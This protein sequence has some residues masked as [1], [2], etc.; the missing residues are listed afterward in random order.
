MKQKK[1]QI[2]FNTI[3]SRLKLFDDSKNDSHV[4]LKK[5]KPKTQNENTHHTI[6]NNETCIKNIEKLTTTNLCVL[7]HTQNYIPKHKKKI[8]NPIHTW[9]SSKLKHNY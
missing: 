7:E 3:K 1:M 4:N 6:C 5:S 9:T 2:K 8:L